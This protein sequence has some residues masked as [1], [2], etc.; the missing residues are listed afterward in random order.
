MKKA[1]PSPVGAVPTTKELSL[2]MPTAFFALSRPGTVGDAM[3]LHSGC[4][5]DRKG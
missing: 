3:S 2:A 4:A 5:G 1:T